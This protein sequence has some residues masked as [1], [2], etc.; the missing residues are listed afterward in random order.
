MR[1]FLRAV[2]CA[3]ALAIAVPAAGQDPANTV[4]PS[5]D[6]IKEQ[7]ERPAAPALT[8]SVLPQLRPTFRSRIDQRVFVPTLEEDLR[9]TFALTDFQRKYAEYSSQCRGLDLGGLFRRL[10][11]A[12][13]E[14]R[15]RRTREQIALEVA[16]IEAARARAAGVK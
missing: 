6:R 7:V 12:L 8:P 10:D 15:E 13:E 4:S 1:T 3:A 11:K 14:S 5:V 16:E 2:T 9:K